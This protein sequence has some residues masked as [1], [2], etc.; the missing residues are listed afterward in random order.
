MV[1]WGCAYVPSSWMMRDLPPLA[2]AAV[3]LGV[4]GA[5]LIAFM[6]MREGKVRIGAPWGVVAWLGLTQTALFYGGTYWGI[7]H[8]SAGL[9]AVLANTDPLF[10]ALLGSVLLG[11]VLAAR[12]WVGIAIGFVG[13][14][15]AASPDLL[16]PRF[17]SAA[18]VVLVGAAAWGL[19]T[20]IAARHVRRTGSPL[21]L[22]G[23]QMLVGAA[24]LATTSVLVE[25]SPSHVG[26]DTVAISL[27]TG[28]IGSAVPLAL[29][30][31][32]LRTGPAG[33]LSA[34][35]FLVPVVGVLTAWPLLG[36]VPSV[37]LVIGVILVCAGLLLVLGPPRRGRLVP[38]GDDDADACPG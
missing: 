7:R 6:S 4:A 18:A 17:S 23:S 21:G 31:E 27:A 29:F 38:S 9:A 5:I 20:I 13:A 26:F 14:A 25:S 32:A 36:E 15:V 2:A 11:E 16:H 22:A 33:E 1:C 10:V 19:G 3:R 30:Y 34:L 24:M 37:G 35:F 12:Q 8:E 28:L